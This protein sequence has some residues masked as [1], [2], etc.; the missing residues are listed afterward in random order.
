MKP[1]PLP[2]LRRWG[3][4]VEV[5]IFTYEIP[6]RPAADWIEAILDRDVL[7]GML[8]EPSA[9]RVVADGLDGRLSDGA[10]TAAARQA[11]ADA[12]GR[13]WWEVHRLVDLGAQIPDALLGGLVR[14]GFDFET[15]P[16]GAYCAAVVSMITENMD[17]KE[18]EDFLSALTTTPIEVA[19]EDGDEAASAGFLAAMGGVR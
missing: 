14:A 19:A 12:A 3:V 6:P 4:R 7:P 10:I 5:G 15:R 16:I 2:I 1:D 18:R 11:V 9:A 13:P 17:K 8:D